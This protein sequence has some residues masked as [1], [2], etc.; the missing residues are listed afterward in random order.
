MTLYSSIG[1]CSCFSFAPIDCRQNFCHQKSK[2]ETSQEFFRSS[3]SIHDDNSQLRHLAR[4]DALLLFLKGRPHGPKT[5]NPTDAC[6]RYPKVT[7]LLLHP[8]VFDDF[9][10]KREY[11][12][13][14]VTI[15]PI[16]VGSSSLLSSRSWCLTPIQ[17][18]RTG[19]ARQR[20][21]AEEQT[22]SSEEIRLPYAIGS[23]SSLLV[24]CR[25]KRDNTVKGFFTLKVVPYFDAFSHVNWFQSIELWPSY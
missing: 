2:I 21:D 12:R 17:R 25:Q 6:W 10:W 16:I 19:Q 11:T 4:V 9:Q 3:D 8:G 24:V 13:P 18:W 23:W 7:V 14:I 15:E 5:T 20:R 22:E 1:E